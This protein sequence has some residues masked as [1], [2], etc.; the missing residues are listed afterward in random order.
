[1]LEAKP[2]TIQIKQENVDEFDESKNS[3]SQRTLSSFEGFWTGKQG[4]IGGKVEVIEVG[5]E[6]GGKRNEG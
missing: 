1:M 5:F 6:Q 2:W 3:R 4:E